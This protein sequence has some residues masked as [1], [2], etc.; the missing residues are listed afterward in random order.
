MDNVL[1]EL[2]K[3]MKL[4]EGT[5]REAVLAVQEQLGVEFPD[6]YVDF[7]IETNGGVGDVRGAAWVWILPIEE[8]IQANEEYEIPELFPGYVLFGSDGG[9]EAY[10]FNSRSRPASIVMFP[11]MGDEDDVS[12]QGKD[13]REFLSNVPRYD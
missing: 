11:F 5:T 10:A 1:Q 9:G 8:L 2:T 3:D 13:L 6:D 7:M 4:G 12:P